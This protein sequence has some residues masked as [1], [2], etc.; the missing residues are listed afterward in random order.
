MS[1]CYIGGRTF[2]VLA[3]KDDCI[4]RKTPIPAEGD[5]ARRSLSEVATVLRRHGETGLERRSIWSSGAAARQQREEKYPDP[6]YCHLYNI[7]PDQS[8]S[9]KRR[10]GLVAMSAKGRSL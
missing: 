4:G 9:E 3:R 10:V 7:S 8:L 1:S 5:R 2:Y 6:S